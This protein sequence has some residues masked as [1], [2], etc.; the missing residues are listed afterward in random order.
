MNHSDF[1]EVI[2][3]FLNVK[4]GFE[5][6]KKQVQR[7]IK[8]LCESDLYLDIDRFL[9]FDE[10]RIQN[11]FSS[12]LLDKLHSI[13]QMQDADYTDLIQNYNILCKGHKISVVL[14]GHV[15]EEAEELFPSD[16]GQ[17]IKVFIA[18]KLENNSVKKITIEED[19]NAVKS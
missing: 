17:S 4:P 5:P 9:F 12:R 2:S 3:T 6:D 19:G 11:E 10:N 15:H 1:R 8:S 13:H 7:W 16:D 18:G 14:A